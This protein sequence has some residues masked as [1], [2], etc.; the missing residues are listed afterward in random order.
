MVCQHAFSGI[1]LAICALKREDL[2]GFAA[3]AVRLLLSLFH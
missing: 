2:I 3:A 1:R